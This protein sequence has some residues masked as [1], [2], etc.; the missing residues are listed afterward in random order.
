MKYTKNIT[1]IA[2]LAAILF[3]QEQLLSFI[4]N[5]QL[6]FFL[7][8][9]YSKKLKFIDTIFITLIYVVLDNLVS[10]S[11]NLLFIPFMFIGWII[12]PILLNT[13]FKKVESNHA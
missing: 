4:P 5:V 2:L 3:I 9:L 12:I 6:T 13:I 1:L 11:F 8:V 10:G 7:F